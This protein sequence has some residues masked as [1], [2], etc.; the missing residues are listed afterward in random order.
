MATEQLL[1]M[2]NYSFGSRRTP[3]MSYVATVSTPIPSV[4][5]FWRDNDDRVENPPRLLKVLAVNDI[6]K[7]AEIQRVNPDGMPYISRTGCRRTRAQLARFGQ[8]G[9][10]GYTFE[11]DAP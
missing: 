5:Q 3:A 6:S 10:T 9:R 2:S 11:K 7:T 4:G 1:P 8:P